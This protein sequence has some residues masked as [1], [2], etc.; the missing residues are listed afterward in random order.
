MQ[1]LPPLKQKKADGTRD[2]AQTDRHTVA[3]V[4][5]TDRHFQK[6]SCIP[7]GTYGHP[8]TFM[9][10]QRSITGRLA[11]KVTLVR[12]CCEDADVAG[13]AA[14]LVLQNRL[15]LGLMSADCIGSDREVT[16]AWSRIV[17]LQHLWVDS[18]MGAL[19]IENR[20]EHTDGTVM[21]AEAESLQRLDS[22]RNHLTVHAERDCGGMQSRHIGGF[23][24]I[25][26]L[27]D[28]KVCSRTAFAEGVHHARPGHSKLALKF[29]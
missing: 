1:C 23:K 16:V 15:S 4:L 13:A 19:R 7:E 9:T 6:K 28:S 11:F 3:A 21:R 2:L 18:E 27:F 26:Y 12:Y 29:L 22:V 17:Q 20:V 14:L 5:H 25:L 24:A 10:R 8:G